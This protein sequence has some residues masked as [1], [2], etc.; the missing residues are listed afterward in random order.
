MKKKLQTLKEDKSINS[1]SNKNTELS[2][3]SSV[4]GPSNINYDDAN[5][6][7]LIDM[8]PKESNEFTINEIN[9][10]LLKKLKEKD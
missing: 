5:R 1:S 7:L 10:Q 4:K 2:Y 3:F 8:I 9:K 6:N